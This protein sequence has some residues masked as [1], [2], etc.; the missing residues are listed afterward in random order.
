MSLLALR[1]AVVEGIRAAQGVDEFPFLRQ[2]EP[3]GGTFNEAEVTRISSRAPAIFVS[4]T[5]CE[6]QQRMGPDA[7]VDAELVA[8]VITT[9][10]DS[11]GRDRHDQALHIVSHM[12][13]LLTKSGVN[14]WDNKASSHPVNVSCRNLFSGRVD[15]KGVALW[16]VEWKQKATLTTE[17]PP[18][19]AGELLT[20]DITHDWPD[21]N[22]APGQVDA[23]DVLT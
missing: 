6:G 9:S 1:E 4:V 5:G 7:S 19:Y 12:T 23:H 14:R 2:V 20:I 8:V 16:A 13:R 15:A 22:P 10:R 18:S 17:V 21:G 3:H 11:D